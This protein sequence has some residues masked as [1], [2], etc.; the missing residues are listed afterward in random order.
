MLYLYLD[1]FRGFCD[2]TI[3]LLDVNFLVGENSTGK[4][5]VLTALEM[6]LSPSLLLGAQ[7]FGNSQ[8]SFAAP[9]LRHF[10]E[11]VSVHSVDRSYFRIGLINEQTR[12]KQA[13]NVNGVLVTYREKD[14]LPV[15]FQV[16]RAKTQ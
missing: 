15:I 11:M 4:T 8:S 12:L 2:C 6:I 14:G 3:P 5:S 13:Q 16:T 1:N 9:E 10:R 7:A